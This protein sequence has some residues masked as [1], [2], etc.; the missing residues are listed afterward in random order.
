[1]GAA[2]RPRFEA[3]V[4]GAPEEVLAR[5]RG[6]LEGA[7]RGYVVRVVGA[8]LDVCVAA[9]ERRVFSPCVHVECVAVVG[10]ERVAGAD[11]ARGADAGVDRGADAGAEHGA[12]AG[13]E[14]GAAAGRGAVAGHGGGAA[15]RVHGLVGPMPHVWTMYACGALMAGLGALFAAMLGWSQVLVDEA[16][17]GLWAA[18]ALA[19]CVVGL[20]VGAQVG[21]RLA[22]AQTEELRGH[23]LAALEAD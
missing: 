6:R 23:V 7:G 19:V 10:V 12:D 13:A 14:R 21:Q 15:T 11:E 5:V 1:M 17:W 20:W 22:S 3:R 4:E 16:P 2:L 8:H 9:A 18:G